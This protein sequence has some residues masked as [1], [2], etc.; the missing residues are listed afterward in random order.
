MV[1]TQRVKKCEEGVCRQAGRHWGGRDRGREANGVSVRVVS[2]SDTL[3]RSDVWFCC[4]RS[5]P[6]LLQPLVT[7]NSFVC[8]LVHSL[9]WTIPLPISLI[10]I[11]WP[12]FSSRPLRSPLTCISTVVPI[13]P[14]PLFLLVQFPINNFMNENAIRKWPRYPTDKCGG[15]LG[16]PFRISVSEKDEMLCGT[17]WKVPASYTWLRTAT[18]RLTPSLPGAATR[19]SARHGNT[20][21]DKVERRPICVSARRE[22]DSYGQQWRR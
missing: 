15:L 21:T 16:G 4:T 6:P 10:P 1:V 9:V 5:L 17:E 12:K 20:T 8:L 7:F 13:W 2:G 14:L 19:P 22:P 18:N 3:I 11:A